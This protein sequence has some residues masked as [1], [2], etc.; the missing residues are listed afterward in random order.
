MSLTKIELTVLC[1]LG[2]M[3]DDAR[4]WY[5]AKGA[6]LVEEFPTTEMRDSILSRHQAPSRKSDHH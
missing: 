1:F 4:I 3:N 5:V 2:A 6:E